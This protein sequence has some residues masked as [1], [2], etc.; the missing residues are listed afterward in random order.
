MFC[1][2]ACLSVYH[3]Y[4]VHAEARKEHRIPWK[5]SY[6]WLWATMWML[7]IKRRSPATAVVLSHLS[8]P[9]S[10]IFYSDPY[11][12]QK[13]DLSYLSCVCEALIKGSPCISFCGN[14][15]KCHRGSSWPLLV[16]IKPLLGWS[17]TV[18]MQTHMLC[19][20]TF[21]MSSLGIT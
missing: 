5:W 10:Q 14:L 17:Q 3:L 18:S 7:G 19:E 11:S 16:S 20:G 12:M 15:R 21:Q 1:L 13:P 2:P 6:S 4:A 8:S 9:S